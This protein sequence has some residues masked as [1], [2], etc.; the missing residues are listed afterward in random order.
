MSLSLKQVNFQNAMN[1]SAISC[2]STS[3]NNRGFVTAR[4]ILETLPV[5]NLKKISDDFNIKFKKAFVIL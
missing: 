1:L 2:E 4:K 5:W 3:L